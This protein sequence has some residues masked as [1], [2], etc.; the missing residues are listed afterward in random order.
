MNDSMNYSSKQIFDWLM[1]LKLYIESILPEVKL[2]FSKPIWC[3][4]DQK[5]NLTLSNL[6]KLLDASGLR[7]LDYSNIVSEHIGKKGLHLNGR[8]MGRLAMNIISL[9]RKL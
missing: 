5:A 9:L 8:G 6:C 4:D 2:I 7:L 1:D 3:L